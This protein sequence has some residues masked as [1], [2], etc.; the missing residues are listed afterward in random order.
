MARTLI[1]FLWIFVGLVSCGVSVHKGSALVVHNIKNFHVTHSELLRSLRRR[2]SSVTVKD[3]KSVESFSVRKAKRFVFDMA[4]IALA[5]SSQVLA[6]CERLELFDFYDQGGSVLFLGDNFATQN[7]RMVLSLFGF[8]TLTVPGAGPYLNVQQDL[9]SRQFTIQKDDAPFEPLMRGVRDGLLY[10]GGGVATTP[11]ETDR[12]SVFIP[13]PP[14]SLLVNPQNQVFQTRGPT[15]GLVAYA[16]GKYVSSRMAV[17]GSF[18]MFSNEFINQSQG[19]NFRFMENLFDWLQF[20]LMVVTVKRFAFC[21]ELSADCENNT[22]FKPRDKVHV[23]FQ[24]FDETGKQL[25]NPAGFFIRLK[26]YEIF[27]LQELKAVE[28]DGEIF[29][30]YSFE[31]FDHIGIYK[32]AVLFNLPGHQLVAP[33]TEQEIIFR[34]FRTNENEIFQIRALPYL[35]AILTVF[36]SAFLVAWFAIG[37]DPK[38]NYS[39]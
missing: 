13:L 21:K 14:K 2:F 34:I 11:Y 25:T 24:A 31:A 26:M 16:Q 4:V 22:V 28:L 35:I 37:H 27:L 6:V 5:K 10:E 20:K 17:T 1:A 39:K 33:G 3:S 23:K 15:V 8:D 32:S 18:K 9:S 38:E 29:F 7:F 30:A 36:T 12:L 19:D